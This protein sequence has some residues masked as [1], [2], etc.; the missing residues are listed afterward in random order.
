MTPYSGRRRV[1]MSSPFHLLVRVPVSNGDGPL[2][3]PYLRVNI[4]LKR[5]TPCSGA[6][7]EVM[8]LFISLC[9][10]LSHRAKNTSDLTYEFNCP[11]K[12]D[13]SGAS[14]SDRDFPIFI[15]LCV[16]LSR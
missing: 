1:I 16:Y 2:R 10:C 6:S 11:E 8:I 13:T 5:M 14:Q 7:Q 4:V 3:V 12:D 15:S 9:V